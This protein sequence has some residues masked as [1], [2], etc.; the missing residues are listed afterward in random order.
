M[1]ITARLPQALGRLKHPRFLTSGKISIRSLYPPIQVECRRLLHGKAELPLDHRQQGIDL[2]AAVEELNHLFDRESGALARGSQLR[3][4]P[5]KVWF[6]HRSPLV[7]GRDYGQ[8]TPTSVIW[9]TRVIERPG[10]SR[11]VCNKKSRVTSSKPTACRLRR[12]ITDEGDSNHTRRVF[13]LLGFR[14]WDTKRF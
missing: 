8:S 12:P 3:D 6:L 13:S 1:V 4:R 2:H 10:S 11:R 7:L 5:G 14:R 9:I